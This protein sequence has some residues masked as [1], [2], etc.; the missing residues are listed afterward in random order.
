MLD[1][2]NNFHPTSLSVLITSILQQAEC[3]LFAV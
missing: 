2:D 3:S 1:E